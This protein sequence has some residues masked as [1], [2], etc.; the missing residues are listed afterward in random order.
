MV[1]RISHLMYLDPASW[2]DS[3][4]LAGNRARTAAPSWGFAMIATIGDTLRRSEFEW[5]HCTRRA[6]SLSFSTA[7]LNGEYAF[8]D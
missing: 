8:H 5:L 3:A 4:D 7:F 6:V 2:R 1:E